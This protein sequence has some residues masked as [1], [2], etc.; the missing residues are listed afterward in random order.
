MRGSRWP[1]GDRAV[2][3][4]KAAFRRCETRALRYGTPGAACPSSAYRRYYSDHPI[5]IAGVG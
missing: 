1:C 5:L 2:F 3:A 4:S